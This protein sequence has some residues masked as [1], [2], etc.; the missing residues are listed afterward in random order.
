MGFVE[1]ALFGSV[2]ESVVS[3]AKRPVLVVPDPRDA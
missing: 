2:G 1:A 3:H